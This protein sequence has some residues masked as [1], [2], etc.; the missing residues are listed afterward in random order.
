MSPSSSVL[1]C[2]CHPASSSI[3]LLLSCVLHPSCFIFFQRRRHSPAS[4]TSCVFI[5]LLPSSSIFFRQR[6][7]TS[8]SFFLVFVKVLWRQRLQGIHPSS[9]PSSSAV[10]LCLHSCSAGFF[11]RLSSIFLRRHP[12]SSSRVFIHLFFQC[13]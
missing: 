6:H 13:G 5:H 4:S 8:S 12:Y 11:R 9:S 3:L 10:V 2:R 1:F 7:P